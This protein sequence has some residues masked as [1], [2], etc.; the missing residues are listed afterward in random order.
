MFC[1]KCGKEINDNVK[2]CPN[3]GNAIGK[4]DS[5]NT[6]SST[7]IN[8]NN[9]NN[10]NNEIFIQGYRCAE[11]TPYYAFTYFLPLA[12][13]L[14]GVW[15]WE[16]TG[17]GVVIALVGFVL[18]FFIRIIFKRSIK[19]DSSTKSFIKNPSCK[20]KFAIRSISLDK[21]QKVRIRYVKKGYLDGQYSLNDMGKFYVI[22][23]D[24]TN[25]EES[26]SVWSI[27]KGN[28]DDF[29]PIIENAFN[30]NGISIQIDRNDTLMTGKEFKDG[31]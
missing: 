20:L 3:C 23:F 4:E 21:I 28:L 5:P 22:S 15:I 8:S 10:S 18:A 30:E 12:I 17:F 26:L 24:S 1:S 7:I 25:K 27:K 2:F 16:Y 9:S 14:L 19:Y 13:L 6:S 29:I 11:D 31:K